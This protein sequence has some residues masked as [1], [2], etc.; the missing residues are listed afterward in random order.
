MI[1][2]LLKITENQEVKGLSKTNENFLLKLFDESEDKNQFLN[3]LKSLNITKEDLKEILKKLPQKDKEKFE[4]I[5]SLFE[6]QK[7]EIKTTAEPKK[8][9]KVT[10]INDLL[11]NTQIQPQTQKIEIFEF[12]VKTKEKSYKKIEIIKKQLKSVFEKE[13]IK[14]SKTEIKEFKKIKSLKELI[15]FANK[16]GLN[17]EKVKISKDI[18]KYTISKNAPQKNPEPV[19]VSNLPKPKINLPQKTKPLSPTQTIN[20]KTKKSPLSEIVSKHIK[21]RQ[22]QSQSQP[23]N[24]HI[25]LSKEPKISQK[26]SLETLLNDKPQET[27]EKKHDSINQTIIQTTQTQIKHDIIKA[28]QS[29]R[30]FSN[31]LHEAIKDYKPPLSKISI[32]MNPKDLGKVEVTLIHR[33]ENLQIKI[34]SNTTQTLN[35][36]QTHQNE[37]KQNLINMGYSEVNMSFNTNQQNQQH[38]RQNQQ[39]Y[40]QTQ[41]NLEEIVIEV[42]YTYA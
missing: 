8:E 20:T 39:K 37:L 25:K 15:T 28:K 1:E 38:Q 35:F 22:I 18:Q 32:E 4:R 34:N 36:I 13:N 24:K 27:K 30:K 7:P 16:K 21:T 26:I 17:I 29:I 19:V 10:S 33:G 6:N 14:L 31:D 40:K 9:K 42:P 2:A 11:E 5:I 41:D 3:L 23:Q 12:E